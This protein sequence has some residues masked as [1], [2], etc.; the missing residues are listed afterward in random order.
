MQ[1][2]KQDI[3]NAILASAKREFAAHGYKK[4]SM[5]QIATGTGITPGNIYAY[6]S[7]K[8]QLFAAVISPVADRID[9]LCRLQLPN[10]QSEP[11]ASAHS[12]LNLIV[13]EITQI[14][15]AYRDEFFILLL[16]SEGSAFADR[17]S[18][19]IKAAA[20]PIYEYLVREDQ[21]ADAH[22]LAQAL[23]TAV[24]EGLCVIFRN[25]D[26]DKTRL[27]ATISDYLQRLFS[28]EVKLY[29]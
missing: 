12:L 11:P 14:Y 1:V 20:R 21:T 25:A 17:K 3:H 18:E 10:G 19:V 28:P 13:Q 24:L 22:L 23:S 5:R 16:G 15:L 29:E 27:A 9:A 8:E 6:F 26:D 4:A 2:P 7:G